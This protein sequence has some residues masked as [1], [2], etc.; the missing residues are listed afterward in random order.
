MR[1][2]NL[3]VDDITTFITFFLLGLLLALAIIFLK[4]LVNLFGLIVLL[5]IILPLGIGSGAV[6]LRRRIKQRYLW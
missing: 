5:T 3:T 6:I 1:R 2:N 4:L